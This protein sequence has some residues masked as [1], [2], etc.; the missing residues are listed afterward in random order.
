[1]GSSHRL[2]NAR[3]SP[4]EICTS[5]PSGYVA[6]DATLA[7]SAASAHSGLGRNTPHAV[8]THLPS[9]SSAKFK[10]SPGEPGVNHCPA[11]LLPA[12]ACTALATSALH[13]I[14]PSD[15][16]TSYAPSSARGSAGAPTASS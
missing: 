16:A 15:H 2:P 3:K 11:L 8:M 7:S 9:K 1:M 10:A 14:V 6:S 13:A 5:N 4:P 12:I